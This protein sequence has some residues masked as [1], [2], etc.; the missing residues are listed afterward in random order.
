MKKW[1]VLAAASLLAFGSVTAQT[2]EEKQASADRI[3]VLKQPAPKDCGID[4]I[5]QAVGQCKSV[6]DA[7]VS[8]ADATALLTGEAD[9]A[10]SAAA[11]AQK[12]VEDIKK[13]A[14]DLAGAAQT[15]AEATAALKD[16]KNPMK[17]KS[18]KK[19]MDYVQ[20]VVGAAQEELPYQGKV[21]AAI[22]SGK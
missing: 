3:A 11:T 7:T 21:V 5:D 10:D 16:V 15:V 2:P 9:A 8:I 1:I 17:L 18:A 19:S 6:A 12:L 20:A 13:A 14:T 4:K 22:V